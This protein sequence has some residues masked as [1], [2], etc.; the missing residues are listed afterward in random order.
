VGCDELLPGEEAKIDKLKP[1]SQL[2]IHGFASKEGDAGFNMDLS[3]HRANIVAGLV[4]SQRAD[5][6]VLGT[7]KHGASPVSGPGLAKD[8][9]P[10][11]FWRSV[12]IEEVKPPLESGEALL[13]PNSTINQSRALLNRAKASPTQANLDLIEKRRGDLKTWLTSIGKSIAA[14]A[15]TKLNRRNLDDFRRF[16]VAAEKVWADIDALLAVRRHADAAKDTYA[17]WAKG[18]GGHDQGPDL[19]AKGVPAGAKYHIDIF[20]EGFFP[21]A[22]NLGILDRTSTT[23]VSGS[24]VPNFIY[25]R[26][27]GKDVTVNKIPIADHIAD[28]V[29]AENGP[30][31]FPGLAD[32]IARIIAPGG[33]I[34]LYNP[35][36]Q[37]DAH[38]RVAKA[39]GGTVTKVRSKGAIQTT[40]VAP[41][42]P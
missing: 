35:D 41:S 10:L 28:L 12:I 23:G 38:D 4:R 19:H 29:T 18:A 11:D 33:T 24:R 32:E 30:I 40:I 42:G 5:C 36:S 37:E 26:F 9:Q 39:V 22:I 13:D 15:N 1:G 2:N 20:G 17:D 16:Y 27:S 8:V 3:C 6:P 14:N 25:R 21:G 34:V 31:G 7:F